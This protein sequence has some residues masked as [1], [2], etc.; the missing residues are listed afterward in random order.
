MHILLTAEVHWQL[1]ILNVFFAQLT[2]DQPSR[3][4]NNGYLLDIYVCVSAVLS[5]FSIRSFL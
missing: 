4:H 2:S 3:N 5:A 1:S